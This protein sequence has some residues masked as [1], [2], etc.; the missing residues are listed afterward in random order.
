[1]TWQIS[2]ARNAAVDEAQRPGSRGHQ[3][4]SQFGPELHGAGA[5]HG[6]ADHADLIACLQALDER[7]REMVHLAYVQ[8]YSRDELAD[9][10]SSNV[11]DK[12]RVATNVT[13]SAKLPPA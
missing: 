3:S 1:M 11:I 7:R 8:G 9:R 13:L 5:A 12:V 4:M 2:I 10:F 6:G